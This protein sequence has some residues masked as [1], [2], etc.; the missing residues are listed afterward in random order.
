MVHCTS[1]AAVA[2]KIAR[3]TTGFLE[4]ADRRRIV[5]VCFYTRSPVAGKCDDVIDDQRMPSRE[6][7]P[8]A[9]SVRWIVHPT[10]YPSITGP[11]LTRPALFQI[12]SHDI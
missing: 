6:Y 1:T 8:S 4:S 3:T 12:V 10:T 5:T 7:I 9:V 2:I 11:L